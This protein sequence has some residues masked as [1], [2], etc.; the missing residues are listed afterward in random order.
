MYSSIYY[1]K[2]ILI[3]FCNANEAMQQHIA[4]F[5]LQHVKHGIASHS[6]YHLVVYKLSKVTHTGEIDLKAI[7]LRKYLCFLLFVHRK[8][9]FESC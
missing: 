1:I 5:S 9:P 6:Y 7:L 4:A 2:F 3:I 8:I